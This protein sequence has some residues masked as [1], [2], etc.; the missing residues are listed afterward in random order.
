MGR[1]LLSQV[2]W[3]GVLAVLCG[4]AAGCGTTER[5]APTGYQNLVS[6]G[7]AYLAATD[8]LERPPANLNDLKPFLE[9]QGDPATLLR[10]PED[11]EDYVIIWGVD[12]RAAKGPPPVIAYEKTGREG[13]RNVLQGRNVSRV[14]DDDF[15]KLPFPAGHKPP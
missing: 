9:K 12:Y 4:T 13:K 1:W 6:V 11:G 8:T 14:S 15:R 7:K 3:S 2:C 10:S 5:E